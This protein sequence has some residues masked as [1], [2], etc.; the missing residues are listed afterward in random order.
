MKKLGVGSI[1]SR[2]DQK[3]H[4]KKIK[5]MLYKKAVINHLNRE[6]K[7]TRSFFKTYYKSSPYGVDV[8][9]RAISEVADLKRKKI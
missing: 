8:C 2:E 5:D 6:L 7:N 4:E 9:M 1:W 3:E